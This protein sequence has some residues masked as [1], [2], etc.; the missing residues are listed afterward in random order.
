MSIYKIISVL[1]CYPE[2]E[3][4]DSIPTI[5]QLLA[6]EKV[7]TH[8]LTPLLT[9]LTTT[10]IITLQ[11]NYVQTFDRTPTHSLHLF[12]HI[13]GEDRIRGQAMVDL[14]EEYKSAGFELVSDELPDYLP[15]FLEF[16]TICDE[17]KATAL[18]GEA[19]DVISH[20]GNKLA[21]DNSVYAGIFQVLETLSPVKPK[22]L[23]TPPIRD[24][25][26]ALEKFGPNPEGIE[27]LL[28][29]NSSNSCMA[30]TTLERQAK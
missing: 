27:P 16:L 11:E 15:L 17:D 2:Q 4:L 1:L 5:R 24:M 7:D 9:E 14:M 28:Q 3:L 13:H 30:S 23:T 10:D 20:L 26:E 19:I 22:P 8:Q 21:A 25:D 29:I 12:E 18:L 6:D